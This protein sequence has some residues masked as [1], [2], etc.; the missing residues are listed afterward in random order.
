[1]RFPRVLFI[2][3]LFVAGS[4]APQQQGAPPDDPYNI[5]IVK[6]LVQFNQG[7]T[8]VSVGYLEKSKAQMGDGVSIALLKA[9]SEQELLR[10]E[11]VRAFL[12]IIRDAFASPGF[13]LHKADAEP[14]ITLFLLHYLEQNLKDTEVRQQVKK[15]DSDLSELLTHSGQR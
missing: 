5:D 14:K 1:M 15:L 3:I 13:I 7:L 4:A 10:P 6:Q 12:P 8:R 2:A 9:F 11:N